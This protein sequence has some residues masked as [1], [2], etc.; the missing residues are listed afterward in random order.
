MEPAKQFTPIAPRKAALVG[1]L[2]IVSFHVAYTPAKPGFFALFIP[3]Y[4]ASLL[5]LSRLRSTRQS[6]YAG[7]VV[8]FA[9]MAP[10]LECFWR[11]FGPGAIALW[12]VLALWIALFVSLAHLALTKLGPKKAC[13]LIPVLWTGLEYFRSELYY[14]KFSWLNLGYAF[15]ESPFPVFPIF[16]GYGLG[17]LIVAYVSL[18]LVWR[19]KRVFIVSAAGLLAAMIY[20]TGFATVAQ[21]KTPKPN[22]IVAGVQLEFADEKQIL[23]ALDKV[24]AAQRDTN[25]MSGRDLRGA[26]NVDLV[27]LCEYALDGEPSDALKAWCRTNQKFLIVGGKAPAPADNFYDTAFVI[28]T[29]GEIVFKQVKSV[30]IQFFKDGL[31]A[32]EQ[33][34]WESPWGKIGICICYDLSYTRVT[35]ELV[36]QGAQML[37]VPTMDVID[38]GRHQHELH[39]RVAPVRAAEYNIP[40]FRVASSGISQ[41]VTQLGRVAKQASFPGEEE[42][43]AFGAVVG[44]DAGTRPLD[45]WLAPGCVGVTAIFIGWLGLGLL[46]RK[47]SLVQ[48]PPNP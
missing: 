15:A 30:P 31:P 45:R 37:I 7:F 11:I 35:D 43:I 26:T 47:R 39:A 23:H 38:W 3:G 22:L 24:M 1:L 41:G 32:P 48:N 14:L 16:G 29:N 9:C 46:Q 5:Q 10:Q 12:A 18:F 25:V 20:F 21:I 2:G 40:I 17:L 28:S 19:S 44:K 4:A 6:F 36:R 42:I 13:L 33:K 27:V 34:V 8:G